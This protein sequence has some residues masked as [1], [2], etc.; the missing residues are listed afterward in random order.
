MNKQ[1]TIVYVDGFNLYYGCLRKSP[2]KWLDL[3]TLFSKLLGEK[4]E[5]VEIKYFTALISSR[6]D[7]EESMLR[8][9][10]Y[11][12]ALEAYH[13][14]TEII[15]GHYLTHEVMAKRVNPKPNE[16]PFVKIYKTEE[17]G[18]D[19]NIAAHLL[20]DAWLNAY[21][22]AVLVSNDSDLATPLRMVKEQLKKV[23]GVVFPNLD[24]KRRPS[25][26]LVGCSHFVKNI[27]KNLLE[28]SQLPREIPN[29]N[30]V[31]PGE[32]EV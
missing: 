14:K 7:N 12:Q 17:K 25:R 4:H 28:N 22:C 18:S 1:R 27:R 24:N 11:L 6:A 10:Y 13:P 20:N 21:D 26:Q 29:T 30:I 5:I 3:H 9:K 15:Y 31:K 23:V 32:W 8:Q 19:V 2:Y 16:P